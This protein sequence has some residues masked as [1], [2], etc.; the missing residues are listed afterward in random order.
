MS[1]DGLSIGLFG[2]SFNPAHAGHMH[3]AMTGLKA[4]DLD[5]IW[6]MVA[7]QNPLKPKQP[8][9][10]SR[11]NSVKALSLPTKMH[12]SHMEQQFG[13]RYTVDTIRMAQ[14]T[15]PTT[16]FVFMMGADN[17][18]QLPQWK[19]WQEIMRRVPVAVIARPGK[20]F[21]SIKA[22]LGLA[23]RYYSDNRVSETQS[24]QIKYM[25][26]P[27]WTYLTLPLNNLSSTALRAT[28]SKA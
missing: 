12:I 15:W 21:A 9:Y 17:F 28:R 2:G 18:L 1:F 4:L 26:P 25:N 6:W 23:A 7:P 20:D 16:N 11:V 24:H 8:S 19:N 13:T 10:T 22:R 14:Q 3:V 5:S 27:A